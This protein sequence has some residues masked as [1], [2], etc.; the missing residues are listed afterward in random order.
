MGYAQRF[1]DVSCDD[2]FCGATAMQ[3]AATLIWEREIGCQPKNLCVVLIVWVLNCKMPPEI[4]H[5][6]VMM[7]LG[8]V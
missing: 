7:F 6:K 2:F 3:N 4:S 8:I 5:S 1:G